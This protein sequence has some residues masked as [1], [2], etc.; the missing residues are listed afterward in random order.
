MKKIFLI[1]LLF[2][3]INSGCGKKI[4]YTGFYNYVGENNGY[5]EYRVNIH[6]E[7]EDKDIYTITI[8]DGDY[9]VDN[10]LID[11]KYDY[12]GNKYR[13]TFTYDGEFKQNKKYS[14]IVGPSEFPDIEMTYNTDIIVELLFDENKLLYKNSKS[15]NIID[16]DEF[17]KHDFTEMIKVVND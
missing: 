13:G 3:I 7:K 14:F 6:I 17:K 11:N 10:I 1:F 2:I 4:D 15:L 9:A 5:S 12:Y 8:K 16:K